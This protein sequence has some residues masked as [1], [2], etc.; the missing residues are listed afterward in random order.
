MCIFV[1]SGKSAVFVIFL[2]S[3]LSTNLYHH[4]LRLVVSYKGE[5]FDLHSPLLSMDNVAKAIIRILACG[6]SRY[7]LIC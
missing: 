6:L 3:N 4:L 5:I 1:T 7:S 2:S